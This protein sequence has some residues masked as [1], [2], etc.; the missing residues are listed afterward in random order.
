MKSFIYNLL[1]ILAIIL[2][3]ESKG[4]I[5]MHVVGIYNDDFKTYNVALCNY[6]LL[7]LDTFRD[8]EILEPGVYW[9]NKSSFRMDIILHN[10]EVEDYS[11]ETVAQ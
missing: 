5:P 4:W 7:L 3:R 10:G 1:K 8:A 6:L 9:V 2:S 11:Y